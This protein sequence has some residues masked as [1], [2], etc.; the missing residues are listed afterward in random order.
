MFFDIDGALPER[1]KE[2]TQYDPPNHQ[3]RRLNVEGSRIVGSDDF[4]THARIINPGHVA[5]DRSRNPMY[6]M[7][8]NGYY[9]DRS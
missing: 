7:A 9:T 2:K 8:A 1:A 4:S 5:V 3:S 6:T